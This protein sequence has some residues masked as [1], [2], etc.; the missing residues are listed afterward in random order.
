MAEELDEYLHFRFRE[1][2][3]S[4]NLL[5]NSIIDSKVKIYSS[6]YLVVYFRHTYL[7]CYGS[8]NCI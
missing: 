4:N 8:F 5:L 7:C 1:F 2:N 6:L 3:L